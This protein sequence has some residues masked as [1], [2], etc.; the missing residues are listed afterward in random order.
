MGDSGAK[1]RVENGSLKAADFF[2]KMLAAVPEFAPLYEKHI[3]DYGQLMGQLLM[4]DFT[5][6]FIESCRESFGE[7]GEPE[8]PGEI[9]SK[10]LDFLEEAEEAADA[11]VHHLITAVLLKTIERQDFRDEVRVQL[12]PNLMREFEEIMARDSLAPGGDTSRVVYGAGKQSRAAAAGR[13]EQAERLFDF[14]NPKLVVMMLLPA[15]PLLPFFFL[16]RYLQRD[17]ILHRIRECWLW[18]ATAFLTCGWLAAELLLRLKF[19][20]LRRSGFFPW[21]LT[22]L[23]GLSA[24]MLFEEI[25]EKGVKALLPLLLLDIGIAIYLGWIILRI[26]RVVN[27]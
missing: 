17:E 10:S 18:A 19:P 23:G 4:A 2:E 5:R 14:D 20:Q 16:G 21:W 12:G 22:L 25:K 3:E 24:G 15:A 11:D 27:F 26:T 1:R 13:V 8:G 9:V 6:F 7:S